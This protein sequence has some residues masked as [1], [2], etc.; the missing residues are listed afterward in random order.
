MRP[1]LAAMALA[2][3]PACDVALRADAAR[4]LEEG[5]RLTAE[6]R[7]RQN[8]VLRGEILREDRPFYGTAV[9]AERGR[10][11]GEPLPEA[12]EG[13]RGLTVSV[14]GPADVETIAAAVTAATDIPVNIRTRYALPDGVVDVPI[15]TRMSAR[16]TGPLSALL[17]RLGARMD[18][19][20]SYDGTVITIDRMV[21]RTW[22][23]ALPF[24]ATE[25]QDGVTGATGTS[26]SST[27]RLDPWAELAERLAPLAPP[28]AR[29]TLS[30]EAGRVAVFGPP[31]VQAAAAEVIDDIAAV[32][33]MRIGLEVGVYFVDSDRADEFGLSA[34]VSGTAGEAAGGL[35]VT[36]GDSVIDFSLLARDAAV[37]DYRL[38]SAVG[39]SGALTPI[40]L[41]E[42]RSY[43]RSISRTEDGDGGSTRSYEIGDLETGLSIAALP[44]LVGP[45]RIQ[46][47]LTVTQRAFRGFDAALQASTGIQAPTVDNRG[48]HNRTVLAPGETLVLSGYEQ[49]VARRRSEGL[50]IL[51]VIGL[52]GRD[53][54]ER[55]KVRM[56]VL[57]RPTLIPSGGRG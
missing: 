10:V 34:L 43:L 44:R 41:T 23:L 1:A 18:V 42:Q 16:H 4:G 14:P 54:V 7:A 31:S 3:L 47:A 56:V 26:V 30:P 51:R 48:I 20:W 33:A 46:L 49:D 24:G 25:V 13:A 27:S 53:A 29:V 35:R 11:S 38:A 37:V 57:V 2:T 22:R 45:R 6:E 52:G 12:V 36:R 19:G 55:R 21:R 32:A 8:A 15:Q 5:R 50:G 39:Q 40:V 17:D 28:P 9:A